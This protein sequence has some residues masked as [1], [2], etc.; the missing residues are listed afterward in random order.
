M[1]KIDDI[2][3]ENK[4]IKSNT[5]KFFSPITSTQTTRQINLI[6]QRIFDYSLF[7]SSFLQYKWKLSAACIVIEEHRRASAGKRESGIYSVR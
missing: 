3:V 4:R 2:I 7:F 1:N 6:Q 5:N